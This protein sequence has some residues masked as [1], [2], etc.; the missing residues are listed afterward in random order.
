M[1]QAFLRSLGV[2]AMDGLLCS[3][4]AVLAL[5]FFLQRDNT[6]PVG[7]MES[8]LLVLAV[9]KQSAVSD[10]SLTNSALSVSI[11]RLG[12]QCVGK[13]PVNFDGM[14]LLQKSEDQCTVR[15]R[16]VDC[17]AVDRACT[18]YLLMNGLTRDTHYQLRFLVTNAINQE[19]SLP[20]SLRLMVKMV[21]GHDLKGM[22]LDAQQLRPGDP[23]GAILSVDIS[24]EGSVQTR[25]LAGGAA[26]PG[27]PPQ[28]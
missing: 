14:A 17:A 2:A 3:F 27:F 13:W 4:V 22:P 15:A 11:L 6:R 21:D 20:V 9:D 10:S 18:G 19:F 25:W 28:R 5:A 1:N 16:W 7:L 8:G 12:G 24:P 26:A 23:L